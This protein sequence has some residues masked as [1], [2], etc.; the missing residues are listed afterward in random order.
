MKLRQKNMDD[1]NIPN[2]ASAAAASS[3]GGLLEGEGA[4]LFSGF[5]L[6]RPDEEA[7]DEFEADEVSS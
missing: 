1:V 5:G 3:T 2:L 4:G 6:F 7:D